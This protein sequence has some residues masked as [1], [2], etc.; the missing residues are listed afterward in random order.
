MAGAG[1]RA[2]NCTP[3][4]ARARLEHARLYLAV[5]ETVLSAETP[6][7]ATVAT[8]NAVLAAIAAAD[9][10]CCASAGSRFRGNDHAAAA[11]HLAKVTGDTRLGALL[12]DVVDLKDM[13]HYGLGNVAVSRAKSAL[14]KAR[15]LVEEA[16]RRVR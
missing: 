13:G 4:D 6:Q 3:A 15:Q 10:I 12:R 1:G 16:E 11:A 5:A 8:G 7:E 14:R 9:A 2:Q